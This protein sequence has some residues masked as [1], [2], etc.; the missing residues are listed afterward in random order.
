MATLISKA[1]GNLTGA[2]TF[3]AAE[4]GAGATNLIRQSHAGSI[5]AVGTQ[6][7]VAFTVTNGSVID[8][9]LLWVRQGAAGSTG[10]FKVELQRG[11]ATMAGVTVNKTD[12][13]EVT[14]SNNAPVFFRFPSN[15]TGDGGSNWTLL[16]TTTGTNAVFYCTH[17]SGATNITRA[18]RTTTAATPGAGDDLYITGELTGAGTHV[19]FT[20]VMNSTAATVY[21]N[22]TINSTTING[23]L[24]AIS[25]WG[26]L[27]FGVAAATNYILRVAGDIRVN[28]YGTLNIGSAGAEIPRNSTAVLEFQT[29]AADGDFGLFAFDGAVVNI[30]GL[31]RTAG[32]NVV[33]CKL[34][35]DIPPCGAVFNVGGTATASTATFTSVLEATGTC[36]L[37][38]QIQENTANSTHSYSV[39][40]PSVTNVTQT[41]SVWLKQGSGPANNRYVRLTL[42]NNAV[43][44][45]V[46]N[47][48]WADLDLQLGTA[49]AITNV[50]TGFGT[51]V[52]MVAMAGG[53]WVEMTGKVATTAVAPIMLLNACSAVG[54]LS[55]LGASNNNFCF[56]HMLLTTAA[57]QPDTVFNVNADT[58]WLAGDVIAISGTNKTP[59]EAGLFLLNADAGASSFSSLLST[60]QIQLAFTSLNFTYSGTAPTQADIALLTRNVKIRSTSTT[61]MSFFY[62]AGMATVTASW[63]E[64]SRLGASTGKRGIEC[65]IIATPANPKTFSY[66]SLYAFDV[67]GFYLT[68]TGAVS[69]NVSISNCVTWYVGTAFN[70]LGPVSNNDWTFNNNLLM[71]SFAATVGLGDLGGTFTNNIVCNSTSGIA[72]TLSEPN[73]VLGTFNNNLVH[74][75]SSSALQP[76]S[77]GQAGVINNFTAWRCGGSGVIINDNIFDITLTNL[78]LFGNT[79]TNFSVVSGTTQVIGAVVAGDALFPTTNGFMFP[80]GTTDGVVLS[81]V[82]MSGVGT[83]LVPH[84][85]ADLA[86]T[87]PSDAH[88][89]LNNCKFGVNPPFVKTNWTSSTTV[90]FGKYN[91]TAGDHRCEMRYGQVRTD[92]A[93]IHTL[94]PSM[95]ITPASAAFKVQSAPFTQGIKVPVSAGNAVDVAVWV[96]KSGSADS[97]NYNGSQPRLIQRA[98]AALGQPIDLVLATMADTP[99]STTGIAVWDSLSS[100]LIALSN[101]SLTSRNL[102]TSQFEQGCK[103]NA[104]VAQTAGKYYWEVT[105]V[106]NIFAG[107]GWG[108][109]VCPPGTTLAVATNQGGGN[110]VFIR[111]QDAWLYINGVLQFALDSYTWP[112]TF[113]CAADLDSRLFWTRVNNAYWNNSSLYAPGGSGGRAIPAGPMLPFLGQGGSNNDIG[114]VF[115]TNFGAS[116][117]VG[118]VPAGYGP[119]TGPAFNSDWVQLAGTSSVATDDG[120]WEFIIDCDGVMG[121]LNVDD[122]TFSGA[123]TK[124]KTMENWYNGMSFVDG[125]GAGGASGYFSGGF[126]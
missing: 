125:G 54:T 50:G 121:W 22:G 58:G 92:T 66:C 41:M 83:G 1:S 27:S 96:K 98:N 10:T 19:D 110:A 111:F 94:A 46:T 59:A 70:I 8:G 37:G 31:S 117:F 114:S 13:P 73:G 26:T 112:W 118:A 49:S 67:N 93:L 115:S 16:L 44:T 36:L 47:G 80:A 122:W 56:D 124:S 11:G 91:Q 82:D 95:R 85:G 89:Q 102:G 17:V 52:T 35:A 69:A 87:A 119:W 9:V 79:T 23:G 123:S 43:F 55:Y 126:P 103:P 5:A 78:T 15:A 30:A 64:F 109:G 88:I 25:N 51:S 104:L 57:S 48:F 76:N 20:V 65:E 97:A 99:V 63:A 77:A 61:F 29:I 100:P 28:Q 105:L 45:S 4:L 107:F 81:N 106:T 42:G 60:A 74:S 14:G 75:T 33:K 101:G 6:T 12:L 108:T 32:K 71:R 86:F 84:A 38:G 40:A 39:P 120:V 68:A 18:L 113:A 24:I 2:T 90:G 72:I 7:S 53:W 21:G 62:C 34:T 3:A 116:A